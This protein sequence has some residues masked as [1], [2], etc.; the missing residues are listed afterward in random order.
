VGDHR[1]NKE[2]I[3]IEGNPLEKSIGDT[4]KILDANRTIS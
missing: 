1:D 2:E 3:S 4:Y